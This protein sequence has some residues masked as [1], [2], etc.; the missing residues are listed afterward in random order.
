MHLALPERETDCAEGKALQ[1]RL[2]VHCF[3]CGVLNAKGLQIRSRWRGDECVC[4]WQ[5]GAEHVGHPGLVYGGTIASVVD[6]HAIWTAL[7]HACTI[8][9]LE[10]GRDALPFAYVTGGLT[11]DYLK[12]ADIAQ[13][14]VLHARIVE[15]GERKSIVACRVMQG[16]I[17]RAR[18]QVVAV[19]V[20]G[21]R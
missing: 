12:P 7:S 14:L 18:A 13:P 16:D 8:D 19:R 21:A 17:T 9:G 11:V 4:R 10:L 2:P 6:C 5:P 20:A 3:G 1:E 15:H